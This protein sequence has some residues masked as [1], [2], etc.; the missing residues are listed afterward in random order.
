M[1]T[2][3]RWRDRAPS[4]PAHE[5]HIFE[6]A[7]PPG[8]PAVSRNKRQHFEFRTTELSQRQW[9]KGE[10]RSAIFEEVHVRSRTLPLSRVHTFGFPARETHGDRS[11]SSCVIGSDSS[12]R[13]SEKKSH[14][15]P[16]T[17][18]APLILFLS[19][20]SHSLRTFCSVVALFFF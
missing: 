16:V 3:R 12:R 2:I 9:P 14:F 6:R 20:V 10:M 8:T 19:P 11:I 15:F 18:R 4:D 13:P 1:R 7:C 5:S 17:A